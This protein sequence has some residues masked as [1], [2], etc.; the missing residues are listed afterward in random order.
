MPSE[1]NGQTS[2]SKSVATEGTKLSWSNVTYKISIPT[3]QDKKA[4]K[5][6][7][8]NVSGE[9]NPGEVVAIMG[10]SGAGKS[11]LL[12]VLAGRIANVGTLEGEILVNGKIRQPNLWKRQVAYVEQDDV[13]YSNLT[14]YETLYYTALLRLP[15]SMSR[16]AKLQRV[17][18]I[19]QEL[20]LDRCRNTYI[21][22]A[23][24]KG[25]SGGERK[26][27]AIGM[28]LMTSPSLMFL[29]EPTSGLDAFTAFNIVESCK[30]L[31]VKQNKTVL[32][33]IHQPRTNILD[34]FDKIVL[35]SAGKVIFFGKTADAITHF[36][37]LGFD[38]PP[39]TN[40]A[41][42][43]LDISTIDA[44]SP[45]LLKTSMDRVHRFQKSWEESHYNDAFKKQQAADIDISDAKVS[46]RAN[47]I[48]QFFT[49]LSRN[50]KDVVRDKATLG[51]TLGQSVII[52][53]IMGAVFWQLG[54]DAAGI[55]NRLGALFFIAVNLTFG[56]VM[57]TLAVFPQ[58]RQIIKR[59]RASGAYSASAAYIA[60]LVS[61]LPF[62]FLGTIL[63]AAPVY[64]MIGLQNDIIKYLIFIL[65]CVGHAFTA[66][67][68]GIMIGSAV[69]NVRVGQVI[70]PL[71][72]TV[73]LIFGGNLV[74]LGSGLE[75]IKWIQ[76]ISLI[77]YSNKA[78]SQN[79]FSGLTF[80]CSPNTPGCIADGDKVLDIYDLD[81]P[82]LSNSIIILWGIGVGFVILGY[83]FFR[84]SSRPLM[85]L[86]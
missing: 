82:S 35:L 36:A 34:L 15:P 46:S 25:V 42:H 28:E 75:W 45:D 66:N 52:T 67:S 1:R 78:L 60:K 77:A 19:I 32:M 18:D 84:I 44:R 24:Q 30:N 56:N 48:Q 57:P 80:T 58:Q 62:L 5:S 72:I 79:E 17:E 22:S 26:R 73:F 33:T 69:P 76:W 71:I 43:F 9:I 61:S 10:S 86:K 50:M 54:S 65:I 47:W 16:K 7:L 49:L 37:S 21:G 2:G 13:M 14:V 40:P 4:T 11:T 85:R 3:K 29:D 23:I 31:A 59:E 41:D 55:Q 53:L 64:W 68:M 20:G 51:A 83:F 39:R 27:V 6:L 74:N 70:G 81:A 8:S 38:C 63:F 12:N